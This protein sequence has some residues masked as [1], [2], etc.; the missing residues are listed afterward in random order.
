MPVKNLVLFGAGGLARETIPVINAINAVKPTYHL[1][2]FCVEENYYT[3]NTMVGDYPLLGSEQ[4]LIEN[5]SRVVCC[6]AVGTPS[7]RARVQKKLQAEGV[8]FETVIAP[9][10]S[11]G[12]RNKIGVGCLLSRNASISCDCT[13]GD[14]VFING[15]SGIGHDVTLGDYTCM[16]S[17]VGIAGHC[18]VGEEVYI[19]GHVFITPNRR[20][21]NRATVAAGSVVFTHVKEGTTVL[22]NPAKRMTALESD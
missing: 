11:I 12:E 6:C 4:W 19:G 5:K 18:T 15:G 8:I 7:I 2:G 1:L 14:G 3:P 20:I 16:M 13:V 9:S 17:G 21:G 10:A 22:G